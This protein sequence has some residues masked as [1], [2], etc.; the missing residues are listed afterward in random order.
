MAPSA[1]IRYPTDMSLVLIAGIVVIG[2]VVA[3]IF[4]GGKNG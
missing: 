1:P 2:I 4:L 3:V